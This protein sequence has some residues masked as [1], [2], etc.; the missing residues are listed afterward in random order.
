MNNHQHERITVLAQDLRLL[1]A[2][3]DLLKVCYTEPA[4]LYLTQ[5]AARGVTVHAL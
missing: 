5:A 2:T 1:I 3:A 4:N